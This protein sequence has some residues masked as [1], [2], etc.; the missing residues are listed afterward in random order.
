M[1]ECV[2]RTVAVFEN[3]SAMSEED[4]LRLH[5]SEELRVNLREMSVS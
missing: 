3:N 4:K 1:I 2:G 5:Y